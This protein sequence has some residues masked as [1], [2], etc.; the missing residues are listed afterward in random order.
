MSSKQM[1]NEEKLEAI[2]QMTIENNGVLRVVRR[3][4]YISTAIRLI[5]LTII[6]GSL[7]ATYYFLQPV[8][9]LIS[10]NS[11]KIEESINEF[12]K[13][14]NQLPEAG[15]INQFM[16]NLK[17]IK[18]GGTDQNMPDDGVISPATQ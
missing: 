16:D 17:N 10:E 6:L 9:S 7:G 14:R 5:Y 12:D 1:N 4:Q 18:A 8:I 15:M 2:Y 11:G 3:Q 13:L